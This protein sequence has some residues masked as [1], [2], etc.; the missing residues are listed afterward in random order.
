M[1][2]DSIKTVSDLLSNQYRK[3][4]ATTVFILSLRL[5]PL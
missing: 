5:T 2:K 3:W 4:Q 1:Y